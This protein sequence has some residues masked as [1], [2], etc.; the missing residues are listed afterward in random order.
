MGM[1]RIHSMDSDDIVLYFKN[2]TY[3]VRAADALGLHTM[4]RN[5][6]ESNRP[7]GERKVADEVRWLGEKARELL[8][9][10]DAAKPE[11]R[12]LTFEEVERI[13]EEEVRPR[14]PEFETMKQRWG[15]QQEPPEGS[16]WRL[17]GAIPERSG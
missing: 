15:E 6:R 11:H 1:I 12:P 17:N 8:A 4:G 14:L 9:A 10:Y 16:R 3:H 13:W 7:V 5:A 2:V